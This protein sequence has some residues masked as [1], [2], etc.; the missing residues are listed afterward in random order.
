MLGVGLI[1]GGCRTAPELQQRPKHDQQKELLSRLRE[2]LEKLRATHSDQSVAIDV[3]DSH[4]LSSLIGMT[5][6]ELHIALGEPHICRLPISYAPCKN[7]GDWFYSFYDLPD[8]WVG[9]GPELFLTFDK[10][11]K[12]KTA[13]WAF[14]Q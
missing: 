4:D 1:I 10:E 2:G 5:R 3:P 13:Q 6:N 7:E 8:G 11:D 12:C 9:G 14:T